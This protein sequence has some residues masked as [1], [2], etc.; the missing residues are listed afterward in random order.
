MTLKLNLGCGKDIK[1][2]CENIDIIK[3][4]EIKQYNLECANFIPLPYEDNSVDYIYAFHI[5][6]HIRGFL[7]LCEELYRVAKPNSILHIKVPYGS[8]DDAFE[9]PTHVRQFFV[10]SFFYLS[11][12]A[13]HRADYNYHGDWEEVKK[14]FYLRPQVN[15]IPD[16]NIPEFLMSTRNIVQEFEVLLR[17]VKPCREPGV[18]PTNQ[19]SIEIVRPVLAERNQNAD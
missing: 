2:D 18:L 6:E 4:K 19:I 9:D 5:L 13:Y 7:P 3:G 15:D 17:A 14:T 16:Y 1:E 10:N 12:S 11:Q 8:S